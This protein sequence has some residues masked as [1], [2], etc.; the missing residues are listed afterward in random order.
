[1]SL[2]GQILFIFAAHCCI[3]TAANCRDFPFI[4]YCPAACIFAAVAQPLDVIKTRVQSHSFETPESGMSVIRNLL[5]NEGP[6]GLVK[7]VVPKLLI[8]GPKLVFSFTVAQHVI[9]FLEKFLNS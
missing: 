1:M 7:G 6:A 9:A 3:N 2:F 5:K 8:V 4:V